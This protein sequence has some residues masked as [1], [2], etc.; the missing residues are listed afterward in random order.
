MTQREITKVRNRLTE[1]LNDLA[2]RST[3]RSDLVAE[4]CNDPFD[5]MQSRYDLDLTVSTLNVHYSMKKAVETALNLLE[6]GEYG[7]CQDCGEDINPKRL[8][9]IPWTTLCVKCQENRDLQA[10]EAGLERAA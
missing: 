6:S 4:R 8:D 1:K 5:E 10:A 7:I 2:G 3:R 9:A